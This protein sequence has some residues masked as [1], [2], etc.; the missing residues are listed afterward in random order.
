MTPGPRARDWFEENRKYLTTAVAEVA[1]VLEGSGGQ[2]SVVSDRQSAVGG[3]PS[4][5]SEWPTELPP[6]ALETLCARFELSPFERSV[7]LFCAGMELDRAM[8]EA[9]IAASSSSTQHS[10]LSTQRTPVGPTF[11]LALARLPGA[12]WSVLAPARPLRYWRLLDVVP[13][14]SLT[15]TPLRIDERILHYLCGVPHIDERLAGVVEA[16]SGQRSAFSIHLAPSHAAVADKLAGTW[17]AAHE[18]GGDEPL[19]VVQL[20]GREPLDS[21]S[22]AARACDG[23]GLPLFRARSASLPTAASELEILV[24]LWEREAILGAGALLVECEDSDAGDLPRKA[25]VNHLVERLHAPLL[26]WAPERL[27]VRTRQVVYLEVGKP[28]AAEQRAL[29]QAALGPAAAAMNGHLDQIVAQFSFSPAAID[30]ISRQLSALSDQPPTGSGQPSD[31]SGSH[32][33]F[34]THR[35]S[36]GGELWELC[37]QQARPKLDD[38]A[39]RIVPAAGWSDIVLPEAQLALL[40]DIGAQVRQRMKVYDTWGFAGKGNRGLGISVLFAGASGT[41]KTMAAEVLANELK[42]DL[43]RIDLSAVVSK[44]IGET[45][46]N[47][48]KVFDA[49]EEGGAI[50]LFDEADALFGKRSEVKDSHDRYANIEVS[51]LLQRMEAYRGLAILTTNMKQALDTA[52]LRRIRFVVEFPF[53]DAA[54]RVEIWRR[55][56]PDK[57]PTEVLDPARLARLN[58]AG[59]NIR[60]IALYAAFLAAESGE[61]VRMSHLLRAARVEYAKLERPLTEAEAV[62]LR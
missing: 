12:H 5:S 34:S 49:A 14:Q 57:T 32:S 55:I 37:R 50:L 61:P 3:H 47:L 53:P 29:W 38:L 1:M 13:G 36:F 11:S 51:Y 44:Y 22:V 16:A 17:A 27:C 20:V 56:F 33:S 26:L 4:V 41:G 59:G 62:G 45:E 42:L 10:A 21:R 18:R 24:R 58:I 9:C 54:Q 35:S 52:F 31:I 28:D 40:R 15:T 7:L 23:L 46:K 48:R 25:A 30:G 43:Y 39:Q 6:P 2:R 8:S 19:P 60:N